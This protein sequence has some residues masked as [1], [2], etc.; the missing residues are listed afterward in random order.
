MILYLKRATE[1]DVQRLKNPEPEALQEVSPPEKKGFFSKIFS[2]PA[3]RKVAQEPHANPVQDFFFS[4]GDPSDLI[5]FDRA[6]DALNMMLTGE[7]FGSEGPLAIFYYP[8]EEV[9]GDD[10]YGPA[11]YIPSSKMKEF[12]AAFEKLSHHELKIRF[13]PSAFEEAQLYSSYLFSEDGVEVDYIM[14][15]IPDFRKFAKRCAETDSGALVG[16][17]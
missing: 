2:K 4:N 7:A 1:A 16:I 10:G 8:G 6:W 5:D 11:R 17:Y 9:G 13:D 3:V 12:E 14:Q 15:S